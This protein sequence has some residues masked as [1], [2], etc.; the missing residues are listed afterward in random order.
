MSQGQLTASDSSFGAV[1]RWVVAHW[2]GY[3][4]VSGGMLCLALCAF[5]TS[6]WGPTVL[7]RVHHVPLE[8]AGRLTGGAALIGG[9]LLAY[10]SD[11]WSTRCIEPAD[12]TACYSWASLLAAGLAGLAALA[13]TATARRRRGHRVGWPVHLARNPDGTG[14]NRPA[15]DDPEA[16][17]GRR[18]WR[19]I[20]C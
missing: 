6:A 14:G 19:C 11:S 1:G 13:A 15:D 18:S 9:V 5:A 2:R 12:R 4:S 20:C 10:P 16:Q 7:T 17:C 3:A 8:T